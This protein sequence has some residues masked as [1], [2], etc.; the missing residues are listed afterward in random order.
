MSVLNVVMANADRDNY[1]A[2][3]CVLIPKFL[4]LC[5]AMQRAL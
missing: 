3:Y 2:L 1:I 5:I 4:D